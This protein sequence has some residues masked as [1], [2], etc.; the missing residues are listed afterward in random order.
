[1]E[2]EDQTRVGA[3]GVT[4]SGGQQARVS[5]ARAVYSN[6]SVYVF[7]DPFNALNHRVARRIMNL[8]VP[9]LV[10]KCSFQE[11]EKVNMFCSSKHNS[12]KICMK[13]VNTICFVPESTIRSENVH[14]K[15]YVLILKA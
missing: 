3:G 14:A 15:G 13:K 1:M 10:E 4:L 7:D 9:I 6:A 5:I 8:Y 11:H 12:Q 2:S